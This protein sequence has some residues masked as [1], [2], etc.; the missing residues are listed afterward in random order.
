VTKKLTLIATTAVLCPRHP[1][2]GENIQV[3]G[4]LN[5]P[6]PPASWQM[7]PKLG[8]FLEAG[9]PPV[10]FTFGS[11]TPFNTEESIRLFIEAAKKAGVRA[12]IQSNWEAFP[13]AEE[14]P[15]I[16]KAQSIPHENIFPHCAMIV[17][18]GGSGTT[19][20][21]L[22]AGKPSLV[23]AHGFDQSYWG[24]KLQQLGVAG[25]VLHR[26]TV[27]SDDL[28]KGIHYVL[29]TRQILLN[30]RKAGAIMEK[31]DGTGNAVA[32]IENI[33]R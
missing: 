5:P 11:L 22:M 16:Y 26:R 4:F 29:D 33:F 7:P 12:I 25:K 23:V 14:T 28:A 10:Y 1:D 31:E 17:H 15:D 19:Q 13:F 8:A 30:A 2:W 18:H 21:S 32:S 9:E 20:S 27:N 24:R 3:S 6:K